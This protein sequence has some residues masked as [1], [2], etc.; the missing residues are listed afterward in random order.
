[1]RTA[2]TTSDN[3]L[4]RLDNPALITH[5]ARVRAE[6]ALTPKTSGR[7]AIVKA[8]YDAARAEYRRRL[9]GPGQ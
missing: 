2:G 6:L 3:D 8:V 4:A 9:A 1:M 5:W 7:H